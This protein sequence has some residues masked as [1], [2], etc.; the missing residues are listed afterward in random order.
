MLLHAATTLDDVYQTLSPEPLLT[1]ENGK[2][3]SSDM[4]SAIDSLRLDCTRKLGESPY[5]QE[6]I[7]YEKKAERL[8]AIYNSDPNPIILDAAAYTLLRSRAV[9][10]FNGKGWFGV[11]PLV[12]D[13]LKSQN[14]LPPSALGGTE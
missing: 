11:H 13:I 2:I 7:P 4:D 10:E 3:D 14:H 6:S 8:L 9:Q 5:D 1:P 12:V